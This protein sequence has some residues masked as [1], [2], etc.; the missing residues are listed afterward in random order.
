MKTS[1]ISHTA[2]CIVSNISA[3]GTEKLRQICSSNTDLLPNKTHF[4]VND[5]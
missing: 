4:Y 3:E 2:F 1:A 5:C